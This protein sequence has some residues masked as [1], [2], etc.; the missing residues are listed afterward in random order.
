LRVRAASGGVGHSLSPQS[1]LWTVTHWPHRHSS[2][3]AKQHTALDGYVCIRGE[4]GKMYLHKFL[5]AYLEIWLIDASFTFV[6]WR[7]GDERWIELAKD[8][9]QWRPVVL[10][11]WTF[12]LCYQRY[13]I[14]YSGPVIYVFIIY[15]IVIN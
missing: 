10:M 14:S 6:F 1:M 9:V 15:L 8:R 13:L 7:S 2:L 5:K 12:G 4:W 3:D 11:C